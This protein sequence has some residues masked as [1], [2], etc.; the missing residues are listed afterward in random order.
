MSAAAAACDVT[1]A[2]TAAALSAA[3]TAAVIREGRLIA[4]RTAS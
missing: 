1:R 2:V 4:V 3:P